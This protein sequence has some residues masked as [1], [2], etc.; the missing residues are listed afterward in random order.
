MT[1]RF[2][3][4]FAPN[5]EGVPRAKFLDDEGYLCQILEGSGA[6]GGILLGLVGPRD[7]G[8]MRLTREM[9]REI[10][11]A[12]TGFAE[13]GKLSEGGEETSQILQSGGE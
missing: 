4:E 3:L 12:L 13:T 11:R 9:A 5:G 6:N 7:F 1:E 8:M 10:G 2:K